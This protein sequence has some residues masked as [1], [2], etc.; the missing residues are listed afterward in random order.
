M[1]MCIAGNVLM[2]ATLALL[3]TVS[4][5]MCLQVVHQRVARLIVCNVHDHVHAVLHKVMHYSGWLPLHHSVPAMP[6]RPLPHSMPT[7]THHVHAHTTCS[8]TQI[9]NI[10]SVQQ[11]RHAWVGPIHVLRSS[12]WVF[13]RT[14][15]GT[16]HSSPATSAHGATTFRRGTRRTTSSA[17]R[18]SCPSSPCCVCASRTR[19]AR[20]W[21]G[22]CGGLSRGH[23]HWTHEC[24]R[25]ALAL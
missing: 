20:G 8:H 4:D 24:A 21:A 3:I 25:I 14:P 23:C 7:P 15:V 10:V 18:F 17:H 1:V 6:T 13:R 11:R 16:K 9:A 12:S 2:W 22:R 5:S 19:T